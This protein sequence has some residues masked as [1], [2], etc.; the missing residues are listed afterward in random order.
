MFAFLESNDPIKLQKKYPDF[1]SAVN[2][3]SIHVSLTGETAKT[4]KSIVSKWLNDRKFRHEFINQARKHDK[5]LFE[6]MPAYER[7]YILKMATLLGEHHSP[8]HDIANLNYYIHGR[9]KKH[10]FLRAYTLTVENGYKPD[11]EKEKIPFT[12]EQL[13]E[14]LYKLCES[15][16]FGSNLVDN[17]HTEYFYVQSSERLGDEATWQVF[18]GQQLV[19]QQTLEKMLQPI[20]DL[21]C[22]GAN[23]NA[24]FSNGINALHV[25][26]MRNNPVLAHVLI[27]AGA[28]LDTPLE[29]GCGYQFDEAFVE[30]DPDDTPYIIALKHCRRIIRY[31]EYKGFNAHHYS[32]DGQ[33]ILMRVLTIERTDAPLKYLV[34]QGVHPNDRIRGISP[35]DKAVEHFEY[36]NIPCLISLISKE[37]IQEITPRSQSLLDKLVE[38]YISSIRTKIHVSKQ[39]GMYVDSGSEDYYVVEALASLD[40]VFTFPDLTLQ[41]K[42]DHL[43]SECS[44]LYESSNI[45]GAKMREGISDLSVDTLRGLKRS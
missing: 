23:P 1:F 20:Y 32:K 30:C 27:E 13:D 3:I 37:G 8:Q 17:Y 35:L 4:I 28:D 21:L 16:M 29:Y 43:K 5:I 15:K 2:H 38:S 22:M 41:D 36:G 18:Q 33:S 24:L 19:E 25:A 12:Q 34:S 11:F 40:K 26:L 9:S 7:C 31:M 45:A 44:K 42:L 39:I 6:T 10:F 14:A